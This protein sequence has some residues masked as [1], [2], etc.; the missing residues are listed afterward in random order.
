MP[1]QKKNDVTL[2]ELSGSFK[3]SFIPYFQGYISA[4]LWNWTR[5]KDNDNPLIIEADEITLIV[6]WNIQIPEC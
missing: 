5:D 3:E 2:T 1:I 6:K 4:S